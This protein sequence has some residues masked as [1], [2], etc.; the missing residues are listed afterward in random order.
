M[1]EGLEKTKRI[2]ELAKLYLRLG[3]TSFGGPAAHIAMMEDEVVVRKKWLT[4]E[5]FVDLI[6]AT[7]LIPGPNST[8]MA[9]HVGYMRAG[10]IGL[11]VAGASFILPSAVATGIVAW[12]YFK[13]GS[14]PHVLPFLQ[15]VKPVVIAIIAAGAF[16]LGK[17][18]TKKRP[19]LIAIAAVV[20]VAS[21]LGVDQILALFAGG[22]LGGLW[23]IYRDNLKSGIAAFLPL[24]GEIV[25]ASSV[26]LPVVGSVTLFSLFVG[27]L[28]VGAVLYGGGYVL[29]ALLQ[30][31]IVN[32]AG[33]ITQKQLIDAIAV[34]QFTPGPV[35]S[36]A[37]FIGF[38]IHGLT[39]AITATVA[40]F[41]P[42]FVFVAIVNP[43]IPRLRRSKVF[44]AF[45]DAVNV[46]SVALI[47]AVAVQ[48]AVNTLTGW[49]AILIFLSAAFF[50]FRSKINPA[51]SVIFGGIIGLLGSF[52]SK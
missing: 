9:I 10:M 8:E 17:T 4:R 52:I 38:Q 44:S 6:G 46:S 41:L 22:I 33:W 28:K 42:S 39:G 3:L 47:A 29:I 11:I 5:V 32:G 40:I 43:F 23:M 37:T 26:A 34:G 36:A 14:L 12:L 16:R 24:L 51:C 19:D 20:F 49:L 27:F 30:N 31:Q 18:A 50:A 7:N 13:Y 45:L 25:P 15:G 2:K 1:L 35:L 48:F 21:L